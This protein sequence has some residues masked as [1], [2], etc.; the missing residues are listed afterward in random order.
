MK[1]GASA[2]PRP[3][4]SLSSAGEGA[5]PR[6]V[7]PQRTPHDRAELR[8]AI[9]RALERVD[10]RRPDAATVDLLTAQASLETG[11]GAQMYNFNFGGIKGRAPDGGI[12]RCRTKEV[13]DGR[14]VTIRD[15]FR[16]YASLDDGA[17]DY[18]RTMRQRFGAAMTFAAKGDAPG[19]AHALKQ[20]HY[21]TASEDDYAR[22]LQ[23]LS[24]TAA[25]AARAAASSQGTSASLM[26]TTT[27]ARVEDTL[28]LGFA[29]M[30]ARRSSADQDEDE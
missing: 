13:V 15:G 29:S 30:R 5:P 4:P 19:F 25:P 3:S 23:R 22:A 12:A 18:V 10:G 27:L 24:G 14:E 16:A 9:A 17:V 6:E 28:D 7:A 21:Y 20:A 1:I 8:A 11:S 2:G 26:S